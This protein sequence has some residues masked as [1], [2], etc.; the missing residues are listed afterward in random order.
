MEVVIDGKVVDVTA[1]N[2]IN[3]DDISNMNVEKAKD[4]AP[5]DRIIITTKKK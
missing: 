3:P 5:K 1:L 2:S 4:G